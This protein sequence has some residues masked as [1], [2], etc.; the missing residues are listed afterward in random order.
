MHTHIAIRWTKVLPKTFSL[1]AARKYIS[2]YHVDNGRA[3]KVHPPM[4]H[5]PQ[6]STQHTSSTHTH[7]HYLVHIPTH[8]HT[9]T[10]AVE[11]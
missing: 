1:G 10:H 11:K 4:G 8:T 5:L 9:Y 6:R 2:G 3:A 7:N